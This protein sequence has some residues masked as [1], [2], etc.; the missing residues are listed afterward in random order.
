[1]SLFYEKD[2]LEIIGNK[3]KSNKERYEEFKKF[4]FLKGFGDKEQEYS[5][6]QKFFNYFFELES[7]IFEIEWQQYQDY[8]DNWL[9][10][11]IQSII[12]NQYLY[13]STF[14][15]EENLDEIWEYKFDSDANENIDDWEK[16][17]SELENENK[18][19]RESIDE[20][21]IFLKGLYDSYGVYYFIYLFGRRA[22]VKI[23]KKGIEIDSENIDY[24]DGDYYDKRIDI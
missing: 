4:I 6:F 15:L 3:E 22:K 9:Y 20:L 10:F 24:L 23:S 18:H 19:L 11:D 13:L 8:N 7:E 12:I 5:L 16:W 21:V 2:F 17:Y 14:G 1:M